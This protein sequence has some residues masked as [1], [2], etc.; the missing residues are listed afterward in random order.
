MYGMGVLK[1]INEV[2][3]LFACD[4]VID[5]YLVTIVMTMQDIANYANKIEAVNV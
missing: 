3:N 5:G 4:V 2:Q 1:E